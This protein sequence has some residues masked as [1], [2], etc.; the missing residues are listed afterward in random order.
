MDMRFLESFVSVVECGS[1]AE[2]ARRLN[3][4]PAGVGQRLRALEGEIGSRLIV[5]SGRTVTP[6][7]AGLA[8]VE[9]A[10]NVLREISEFSTIATD[11]TLAGKLRIGAVP[12][13]ITGL[14]PGSMVSL[15]EVYP[16]VEI[17]IVPG[18]SNDLYAKVID[19]ELDAAVMIQ[20]YFE[21]PKTCDWG[22]LRVE[23]LI[24]LAPAS[25]AAADAHT[26]LATEP[27]IRYD[28]SLWGGRQADAYLRQAHIRPRERF[29][30]VTLDA[31][32][33]FVD[34]GLGVSLVPDWSPPWPEGLS[35]A[36]LPLPGKPPTRR[37]GLLW[38]R[39]SVRHRLVEAFLEQATKATTQ[40]RP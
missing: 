1:I 7:A 19:G 28:Q 20:P 14:L 29:E 37:L 38:S 34:R 11:E 6:T 16:R 8:I 17:D 27:F 3:L 31:I 21:L 25:M 10:R 33:V 18:R 32:A 12:T 15:R 9:R 4:T 13:A 26:V 22:T 30:L 36:K 40:N 39:A 35:L 5:R 2:A 24:V 23:P